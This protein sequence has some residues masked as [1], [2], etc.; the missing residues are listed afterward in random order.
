MDTDFKYKLFNFSFGTSWSVLCIPY[1]IMISC[2][3]IISSEHVRCTVM[4]QDHVALQQ[5][6]PL[7]IKKRRQKSMQDN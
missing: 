4:L 1:C 5:T 6:L 7:K 2:S 3:R